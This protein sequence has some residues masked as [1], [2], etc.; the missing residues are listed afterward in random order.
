MDVAG[1]AEMIGAGSV[2]ITMAADELSPAARKQQV[3]GLQQAAASLD[4]INAR[5]QIHG[6]PGGRSP[7]HRLPYQ[8]QHR[9][10][11]R[12]RQAGHRRMTKIEQSS[13][14]VGQIIGVIDESL[15]RPTCWRSMP[16]SRRRGRARRGAAFA[17]GGGRGRDPGAPVGGCRQADQ[18]HHRRG[19]VGGE[20]RRR[21]CGPDGPVAGRNQ[22]QGRQTRRDRRHDRGE[23]GGTIQRTSRDQ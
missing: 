9:Q 23:R 11:R 1:R 3:S 20:P 8:N 17:V 13:R 7:H 5:G 4:Q 22:G 16:G 19:I 21:P 14:E 10:R 12:H 15:S 2:E 18:D 6:Q